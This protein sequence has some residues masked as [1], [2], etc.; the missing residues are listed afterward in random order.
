MM[1]DLEGKT[2][3]PERGDYSLTPGG[4]LAQ[5]PG[6]W[7]ASPETLARLGIEGAAVDG[8]D[9]IAL[10][11]GRRPRRDGW[12]RRAGADGSRGGGIDV[13][14]SAP[15]TGHDEYA[16]HLAH[17]TGTPSLLDCHISTPTCSQEHLTWPDFVFRTPHPLSSSERS[18]MRTRQ[19]QHCTSRAPA[20]RPVSARRR[21]RG[22]LSAPY[23]RLLCTSPT[24]KI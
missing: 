12:L 8:P 9:F 5:A 16:Q 24:A 13:T 23:S 10:M 22:Y 1:C 20:A 4:E 11:E 18:S 19:N 14:F 6:H 21:R 7:L 2:L 15:E 17:I 3:T